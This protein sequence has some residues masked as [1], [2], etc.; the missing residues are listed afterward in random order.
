MNAAV[1]GSRDQLCL[2][3]NL[4]KI[5][6]DQKIDECKSLRENKACDFYENFNEQIFD[7]I[8]PCESYGHLPKQSNSILDIED[9]H[10]IGSNKKCCPYF[11]SLERI[12]QADIIFI[13]YNYL[14]FS[15]IQKPIEFGKKLENAIIIIDEAHNIPNVCNESTSA[16]IDVFKALGEIENVISRL[17]F[18]KIMN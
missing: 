18:N 13:P 3:P 2:H 4:Q 6:N 10:Q 12:E 8:S 15:D 17:Y 1:L 9:L 7:I 14:F 16:S 11:I 5:S